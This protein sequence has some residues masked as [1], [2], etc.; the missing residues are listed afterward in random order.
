MKGWKKSIVQAAS[1]EEA[2]GYFYKE[3]D[4][5]LNAEIRECKPAKK[6]AAGWEVQLKDFRVFILTQE[7]DLTVDSLVQGTIRGKS[8]TF[9]TSDIMGA[10]TARKEA[11]LNAG[12]N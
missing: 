1:K 9:R 3:D 10:N 6:V 4:K 8:E 7:V 11:V 2:T 5:T 12:R